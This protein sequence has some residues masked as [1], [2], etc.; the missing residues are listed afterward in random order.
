MNYK[1]MEQK[2]SNI[3]YRGHSLLYWA[4][5]WIQ[6]SNHDFF[7]K[8]GFN[9]NPHHFPGLFETARRKVYAQRK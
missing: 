7:K 4:M 6:M 3:Q 1:A 8:H 2:F 9:F 5:Q